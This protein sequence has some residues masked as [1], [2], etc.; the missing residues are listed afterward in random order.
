LNAF[1]A[2]LSFASSASSTSRS[3]PALYGYVEGYPRAAVVPYD[4]AVVTRASPECLLFPIAFAWRHYL[5]FALKDI[6][7][8]GRE[9]A[10]QTM[11]Y[12]E[13]LAERIRAIIPPSANIV[14]K[15]M[16]GGLAFL[17]ARCS[18][19]SQARI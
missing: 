6:I 12:D 2:S 9:L 18:W 15:K 5:E 13:K 17:W 7:A 1:F 14:E 19:V 4:Y 3:R 10:G 8:A 16:F 11:T